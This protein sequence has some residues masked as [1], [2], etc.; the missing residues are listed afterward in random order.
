MAS[1]KIIVIGASTGGPK[2]LQSFFGGMPRLNASIVLIQH[3]PKFINLSV[4]RS[5]DGNTDMDV[6]IAEDGVRLE[7]GTVYVAPSEVHLQILNNE[8]VELV[9]G[10]KVCFVCPSVN[11][12][13]KSLKKKFGYQIIAV[14]MTGMG[15]DGA[16]GISHVKQI[17]GVTIAQDKATSTIYGMPEAAFKTG[18]VDIVANPEAIRKK[19]IELVGVMTPERVCRC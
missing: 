12:T 3:M 8:R 16:E 4:A 10:P 5:L 13:M 9:A 11:V 1:N 19:F 14:I 2:V 17:G 18:D 15:K 6:G 7:P